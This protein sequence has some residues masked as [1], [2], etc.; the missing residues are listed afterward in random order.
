VFDEITNT[1][2]VAYVAGDENAT[3]LEIELAYRLNSA[4]SE[5]ETLV[6]EL[7]LERA[8]GNDT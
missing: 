4:I 5:I 7:T 6:K 3:E 1:N 8:R 2:L